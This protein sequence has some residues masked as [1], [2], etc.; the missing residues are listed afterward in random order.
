MLS[1]GDLS[2]QTRFLNRGRHDIG[3]QRE[4]GSVEMEA[5]GLLLCSQGFDG[6][7]VR[8]EHGGR[9]RG[10]S[11]TSKIAATTMTDK[12]IAV[13]IWR[14]LTQARLSIASWPLR[15][16]PGSFGPSLMH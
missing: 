4:I 1:A 10:R 7:A 11:Q 9:S 2:T 14:P 15:V 16:A 13:R 5:T 3:G 6:P 12:T 8:T